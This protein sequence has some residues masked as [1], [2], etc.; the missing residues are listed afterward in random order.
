MEEHRARSGLFVAWDPL[1]EDEDGYAAALPSGYEPGSL[2]DE[3]VDDGA[4]AD[5]EAAGEVQRC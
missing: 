3:A 4:D 1:P 5:A 2:E